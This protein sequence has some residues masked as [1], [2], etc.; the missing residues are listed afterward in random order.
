[1]R[2]PAVV[3]GV[4]LLLAVTA[5]IGYP[6]LRFSAADCTRTLDVTAAPEIAPVV[7]GAARR[8]ADPCL[9]VVVT[10]AESARTGDALADPAADHPDV[11]I[12]ESTVWLQRTQARRAWELPV[13]G[14]SIASSPVVLGVAEESARALGWP[15][16]PLT[17]PEVLDLRVG[18]PDPARDPTG[19]SAVLGV[20]QLPS[21]TAT[22]RRL[23]A[24][25]E[26]R[27][28][29]LFARLR[30]PDPLAAFPVSEQALL[31]HDGLVAAY[32]DPPVPPLDYPFTVMPR[33]GER[34]AARRLL[35]E[36]LD[37]RTAPDLAEHGLRRPDG[38]AGPTSGRTTAAT[39]PPVAV[40]D[41][42]VADEML[43]QWAAINLSGRLQILLDVSGSMAQ[44]VPGTRLDRMAVTL[45]ATEAGFELVKPTT[46]VG[47][48]LFSTNLDGDR[49][50][51]ELL[52]ART[53]S[54]HLAG[55]SLAKLRAV[56]AIEGGA[57]GLYD[58]VLAT[59]RAARQNWEPGR[60]NV[61]VVM[62]D[63]RNEDAD[64][65][66]SDTLLAELRAL[67][68]PRRPL[69]LV[70]LGIGPDADLAEL[71][72]IATATG[73]RAFS[74]PDP[75]AIDSIFHGALSGMLCQ[76]PLCKP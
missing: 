52:P 31:R 66:T 4:L 49:D 2:R 25:T 40:P 54:E 60:L 12:P 67:Q 6:H 51:R 61:V 59:Y 1:M 70:G 38:T 57:T 62:T 24:D 13:G 16:D 30:G 26:E 69:P 18:L 72:A 56:R 68:D 21:A 53:V 42:D 50:H 17:W 10:G 9:R 7:E 5:W 29:D 48:S 63:G 28:A 19:L 55:D 45:K 75:A 64:G 22:L 27:A 74:T 3:F 71:T 8:L 20:R 11:W 58:S 14:T 43:N 47:I 44:P 35:A 33:S 23:S 39:V 41:T 36:L 76:P 73:G 46:K 34:D 37:A 32:A 65:I 15:G